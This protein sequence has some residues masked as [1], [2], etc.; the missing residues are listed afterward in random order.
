MKLPFIVY[1]V[2]GALLTASS[3]VQNHYGFSIMFLTISVHF[4]SLAILTWKVRSWHLTFLVKASFLISLFFLFCYLLS[5]IFL[6]EY[7][8]YTGITAIFMTLGFLFICIVHFLID[9][10][11]NR[12][13][14]DSFIKKMNSST[15][16]TKEVIQW[17]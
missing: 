3:N 17:I 6:P 5:V 2:W 13:Y 1:I 4:L 7:F 11:R 14:I 15:E 16:T 12:V 10:M 8:S 9:H